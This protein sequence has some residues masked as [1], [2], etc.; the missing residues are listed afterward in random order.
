MQT[1]VG[2][3]SIANQ[4]CAASSVRRLATRAASASS[5]FFW[6]EAAALSASAFSKRAASSS[7]RFSRAFRSV[8]SRRSAAG[9]GRR[10]LADVS[11]DPMTEGTATLSRE[12]GALKKNGGSIKEDSDKIQ[13]RKIKKHKDL[14][15]D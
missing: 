7:S 5:S 6:A 2:G 4:R 1:I 8:A 13:R 12:R 10:V 11:A 9:S 3:T 14:R 15:R